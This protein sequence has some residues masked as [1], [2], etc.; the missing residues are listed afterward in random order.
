MC[1]IYPLPAQQVP[2]AGL[3]YSIMIDVNSL[4]STS[5]PLNGVDYGGLNVCVFK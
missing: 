4:N 1:N 2:S 5:G 3:P